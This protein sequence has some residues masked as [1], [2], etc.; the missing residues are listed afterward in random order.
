MHTVLVLRGSIPDSIYITDSR[1]HDNNFL[2]VYEPYKWAIYTMDKAYVNL[3]ALYRIHLNKTYFVT[4]AKAT[5]KYEVV[6]INYNTND[7]EGIF[8][9]KTIHLSGYVARKK[10][11]KICVL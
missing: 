11:L 9:N 4:S 3:E 2:N 10:I 6:D 8:R 1:W 5:M 7:L